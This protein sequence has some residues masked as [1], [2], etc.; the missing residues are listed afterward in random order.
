MKTTNENGHPTGQTRVHTA[1]TAVRQG[2]LYHE[3]KSQ[4][5]SLLNPTSRPDIL[6]TKHTTKVVQ[7]PIRRQS[8]SR[9]FFHSHP[10]ERKP[11]IDFLKNISYVVTGSSTWNVSTSLCSCLLDGC[12]EPRCM[13]G[14]GQV[15]EQ[16]ETRVMADD[17]GTRK[18]PD[19]SCAVEA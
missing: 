18:D 6:C 8:L 13:S 16:V 1:S 4:H 7:T 2:L 3:S 14:P 5:H 15:L 19:V 17:D 10:N 11:W 9:C 12:N